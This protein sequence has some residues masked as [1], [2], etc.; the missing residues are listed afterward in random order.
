MT[1]DANEAA[2][3]AHVLD[4]ETQKVINS[5]KSKNT[6]SII[7]FV[8][9]WS[10]LLIVGILGIYRQNQIANQNKQHIDCIIKLFITPSAPGQTRHIVNLETCQIRVN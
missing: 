1:N 4:A 6:K 7:A 8:I 2:S 5:I 10:V 3:K 9:C